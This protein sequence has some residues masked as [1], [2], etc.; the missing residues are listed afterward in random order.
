MLA[1]VAQPAHAGEPLLNVSYDV[2]RELYKDITAA[3]IK[4]WKAR[5]GEDLVINQSHG[6]SSKPARSV[7]DGLAADVITMNQ[8]NDIDILA[9]RGALIRAQFGDQFDVVYPRYSEPAGRK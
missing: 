5:T 6:G 3:F 7:V 9:E 2:T 4:Q 8:A 1:A